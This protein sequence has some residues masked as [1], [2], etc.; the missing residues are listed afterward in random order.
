MCVSDSISYLQF[1]F[2][3]I[4]EKNKLL[5]YCLFSTVQTFPSTVSVALSERFLGGVV[6]KKSKENLVEALEGDTYHAGRK[7]YN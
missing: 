3:E 5:C 1:C 4:L 2:C 7:N 6:L